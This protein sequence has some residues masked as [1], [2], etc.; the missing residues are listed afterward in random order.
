MRSRTG[1]SLRG[2]ARSKF[3]HTYEDIT[4]VE[5]LLEAWREFV[6][7][8]RG[9]DDVQKFQAALMSNILSLHQDLA[10]GTYIHGGYRAFSINDPKP[11][12]I[13]KATVRDRLLHHAIYRKLYPFFDR[14]F[15]SDSYSCRKEKGTHKALERFRALAWRASKNH[16]RTCW[17]LKCDVKKFFA[18]VD[19]A[20][21][22]GILRRYIRDER[23]WGL[24][25]RVVDSFHVT[26]GVGLP[27]GNLTSQ[28][29]V[30]IHMNEFD[31]YV[32]HKLKV[33]HYIRCAD[34]FVLFSHDRQYLVTTL[35]HMEAFLADGLKLQMHPDKV[36]IRTLAS[37]VDFLGW[38][39]FSDHRVLRT[40]TKRRMF[41]RTAGLE[42][43]HPAVQSYLGMMTHGNTHGL[44]AQ[45]G[46]S[47]Q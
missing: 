4:S 42:C 8:K 17:A 11:R 27:L 10:N 44:R 29:F 7:G 47:Q 38:V 20:V 3:T 41:R 26:T 23:I 33:K 36:F 32:K 24:I 31:Q 43:E 30:N 19:H 39:H 5:N 25:D 34:D 9:K 12:N 21:L 45:V 18:S 40:S 6:R 2:G 35:S 22:Y 16:T 37:G 15:I 13:H 14:T 1:K 46:G 28:L